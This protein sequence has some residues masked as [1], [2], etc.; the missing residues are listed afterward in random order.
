ML[1]PIVAAAALALSA[2]AFAQTIFSPATQQ[3]QLL[4]PQLVPFSGSTG[5]FD[6]LVT[7]LTSGTPVTLATVGLDGSLQI[8]TFVPGT[9]LSAA[10]TARVLETARQSLISRG[11]ATPT[12]QQLAASLVGGTL[13]TPSGSSAI[14]GVLSGTTTPPTPVQVRTDSAPLLGG[15]GASNLSAAQLQAVRNALATGTAVTL[16]TGSAAGTAQ[17]VNFAPTGRLSDFEVNQ[18]LQLAAVLLAQQGILNPTA[19]QLRVALFGGAIVASNGTSVP[20]QG[21]LQGQVRNTSN[22]R[23]VNTSASPTLSTS[24][25]PGLSTSASPNLG[26][27]ALPGAGTTDTPAVAR[28]AG[29]ST[30]ASGSTS[31]VGG[32]AS[33]GGAASA[34]RATSPGGAASAPPAT[35]GRVGAR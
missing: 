24:T 35:T 20:V 28:S 23:D 30:P 26:T 2:A 34:A 7:G 8:V 5:N 17:N 13:T 6:S 14:T 22:S 29:G 16:T 18:T 10:D 1:R 33:P 9:T 19:D 21:V 11:I 32:T 12:G 3:V 4:A 15:T 25:S 31:S 27:G